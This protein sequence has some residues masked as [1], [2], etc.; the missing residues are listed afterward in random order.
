MYNPPYVMESETHKLF[1]DLTIK[2]DHQI[3]A[4][5]QEL[6]IMNTKKEN[7]P[8]VNFAVRLLIE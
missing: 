2:T 7:L 1:W 4:R 3:S 6:I 8:E 5:K